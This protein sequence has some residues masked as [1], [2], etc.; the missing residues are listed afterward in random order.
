[1]K[2]TQFLWL[3]LVIDCKIIINTNWYR[4][5]SIYRLNSLWST[6]INGH[7]LDI[8][9]RFICISRDWNSSICNAV[10]KSCIICPQN[11]NYMWTLRYVP[12]VPKPRKNKTIATRRRDII[13][14]K[15]TCDLIFPRLPVRRT[16]M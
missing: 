13:I 16:N 8:L 9:Y 4:L 5:S 3:S 15:R 7:Q 11:F 1:M 12:E 2:L 6:F 10:L 14:I